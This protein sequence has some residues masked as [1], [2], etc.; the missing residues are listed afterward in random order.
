[1]KQETSHTA[2]TE[3]EPKHLKLSNFQME[4]LLKDFESRDQDRH[5]FKPLSIWNAAPQVYG[6]AGSETR[7]AYMRYFSRHIKKA[8]LEVYIATL[9]SCKVSMSPTTATELE[10]SKSNTEDHDDTTTED[11]DDSSSSINEQTPEKSNLTQIPD[12]CSQFLAASIDESSSSSIGLTR[13]TFGFGS[14]L[15]EPFSVAS[16]RLSHALAEYLPTGSY[17]YPN[18]V[19][20]DASKNAHCHGNLLLL[21]CAIEKDGRDYNA[22]VA[23]RSGVLCDVKLCTLKLATKLP[24]C[25]REYQGQALEF[26]EPTA[27]F[28][29][30][31]V[32]KYSQHKTSLKDEG[33]L[34]ALQAAVTDMDKTADSGFTYSLILFPP[35]MGRFDNRV[36][37]SSD[38]EVKHVK[39]P[40]KSENTEN[41]AKVPLYGATMT[42]KIA[43]EGQSRLIRAEQ[44]NFDET[45]F[46]D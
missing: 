7:R 45:S 34:K 28:F 16:T 19:Y 25:F 3:G 10:N 13:T 21:N 40:I 8:S 31:Q 5:T 27:N 39:T 4:L 37:S 20:F 2:E 24:S 35:A 1:M 38:L 11:H 41:S 46:Y 30:R 6:H 23:Q 44:D 14:P 15:R 12:L 18:P 26:K 42:W 43:F 9:E 22:I 17:E 33:A 36:F 32:E 29:A